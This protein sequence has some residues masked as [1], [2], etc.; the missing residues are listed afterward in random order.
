MI[1]FVQFLL[2]TSAFAQN[3]KEAED[4][5]VGRGA[6]QK[7]FQKRKAS[8]KTSEPQAAS[9]NAGFTQPRHLT[10]H[11]GGFLSDRALDWAK[12]G[13]QENVAR[14]NFGVG[15]RLGQWVNSM[16]LK[17]KADIIQYDLEDDPVKLGLQ[18][19]VLFPDVASG[20][21]FYF[22]GGAGLGLFFQQ[23]SNE[24]F[25]SLDYSVV[26]GLRLLELFGDFGGFIEFGVNNHFLVLSDGQFNGYFASTGLTFNF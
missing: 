13:S 26:A 10:L 8:Q 14:W 17:F 2:L 6:A 20:F 16:D 1:V 22:G 23:T 15:Y 9:S 4:V 5:E 24:S 19:M 11:F 18:M 12:M 25:L 21:P 3:E 7:Y